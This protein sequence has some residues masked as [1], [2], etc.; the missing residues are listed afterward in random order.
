[1]FK[2]IMNEDRI[3]IITV[4][5]FSQFLQQLKTYLNKTEYLCSFIK[6]YAQKI[7]FL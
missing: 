4:L 5:K 2:M 7:T 1:M 6:N 3:Q